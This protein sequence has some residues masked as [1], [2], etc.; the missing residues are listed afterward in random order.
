MSQ[1]AFT[2]GAEDAENHAEI[3]QFP[4]SFT[5]WIQSEILPAPQ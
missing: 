2:Q 4:T 3:M 5:F 1:L